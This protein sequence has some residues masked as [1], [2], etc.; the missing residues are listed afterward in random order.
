MINLRS[1][2]GMDLIHSLLKRIQ[3]A[4]DIFTLDI[5]Q[6]HEVFIP[7]DLSVDKIAYSFRYYDPTM[8]ML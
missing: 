3:L 5:E 2:H 4:R 1:V 8:V 6:G 7:S